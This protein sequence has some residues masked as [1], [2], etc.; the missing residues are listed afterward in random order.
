MDTSDE[1]TSITPLTP[2]PVGTPGLSITL[3]LLPLSV[4]PVSTAIEL[5]LS[6]PVWLLVN[7]VNLSI[8]DIVL[9]SEPRDPEGVVPMFNNPFKYKGLP[10]PSVLL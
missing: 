2:E 3:P 6:T 10:V 8:A 4:L 1:V 9:V 7:I 5:L